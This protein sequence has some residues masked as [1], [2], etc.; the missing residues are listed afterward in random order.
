[1]ETDLVKSQ[2]SQ[3]QML[4]SDEDRKMKKYKVQLNLIEKK[5]IKKTT[6]NHP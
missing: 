1:M 6:Y 4:I 3:L 2:I 5:L